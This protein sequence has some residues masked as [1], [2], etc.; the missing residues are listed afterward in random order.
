MAFRI[1][2]LGG[3]TEARALADRLAGRPDLSVTVSLAGR[4]TSIVPHPVP[5][6]IG[7][8]GGSAGL[9]AHL[10][11]ELVDLLVDATHPFAVQMS[12]NAVDASRE[13]AVRLLALRRAEWTLVAG[14]RWIEVDGAEAAAAA[15]GETPRRVFLALGRQEIAA[16]A[17]APQH[18]YLVRSIDPV[19]GRPL[20]NAVHVESRGPFCEADEVALMRTH[21]I[22]IVVSRNS[23]GSGAYAK[24]AAARSL[25]LPVVMIRRPRLPA[26]ETVAT[27]DE[28]VAFIDHA[29]ASAAERGA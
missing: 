10:R 26:A 20:P 28:A 15:L 12:R 16:F 7:G 11:S 5:V 1:L 23:G 13:A 4:V 24:I 6:R 2:I 8:F 18:V 3:T 29:L 27:V 22:D 9:A 21:A 14:D 25:G 19:A 17:A